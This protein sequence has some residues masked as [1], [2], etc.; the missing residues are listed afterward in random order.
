MIHKNLRDLALNFKPIQGSRVGKLVE[1][2]AGAMRDP[3]KA[4]LV[5]QMGDLS[6]MHA[7]R[8]IRRRML[9]DEEGRRTIEE[10]PRMR[11]FIETFDFEGLPANTFGASYYRWMKSHDFSAADRPI[12]LHIPDLE[13]AYVYQRYKEVHD[14]LHT[15]LGYDIAVEEEIAVKWFEMVQTGLPSSALASFV[16][17]LSL[18]FV[19]NRKLFTEYLPHVLSNAHNARFFMSVYFEEYFATDLTEVRYKL[20]MRPLRQF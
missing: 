18:S 5:S 12:A 11:E 8:E 10:K 3:T 14:L 20:K 13:L 19:Q 2:A 15:L 4:D 9:L 7:L 1:V 6:G 17:P 16:G